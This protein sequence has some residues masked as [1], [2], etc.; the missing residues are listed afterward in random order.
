[1][2]KIAPQTS[3]WHCDFLFLGVI[4]LSINFIKAHKHLQKSVKIT[5]NVY[6]QTIANLTNNGRDESAMILESNDQKLYLS[7]TRNG[8][9]N[10][11]EPRNPEFIKL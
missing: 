5:C 2:I 4:L 8:D 3:E 1:M 10:D 7:T 11:Y 6:F 9:Q